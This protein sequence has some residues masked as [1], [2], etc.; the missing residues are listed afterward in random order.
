M[1]I[2]GGQRWRRPGTVED[3]GR[4]VLV[5]ARDEPAGALVK[6][7]EARS[8]GAANVPMGV[9]HAGAAVEVKVIA[10]NKDGAMGGVVRPDASARGEVELPK[11]AGIGSIGWSVPEFGFRT[12]DFPARGGAARQR[13]S[14]RLLTK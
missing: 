1:A 9:V 10:V 12:A 2:D 5:V 4:D 13:T 7:D 8:V 11:N 6:N 3:V 14:P